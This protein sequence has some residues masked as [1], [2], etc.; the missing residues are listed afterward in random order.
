MRN[1]W[2]FLSVNVGFLKNEN[3]HFLWEKR[4]TPLIKSQLLCQLS[5]GRA[6]T[7]RSVTQQLRTFAPLTEVNTVDLF[8]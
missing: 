8:G 3:N 1:G 6:R 7:Y 4:K 2:F 5:Y